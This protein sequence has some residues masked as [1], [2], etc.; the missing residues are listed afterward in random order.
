LRTIQKQL[1]KED[2]TE[3]GGVKTNAI[4]QASVERQRCVVKNVKKKSQ[5]LIF[6]IPLFKSGYFQNLEGAKT[7]S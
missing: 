2:N 6:F 3:Q 5:A 7:T 1:K 4:K